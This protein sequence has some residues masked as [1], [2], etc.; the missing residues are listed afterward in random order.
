VRLVRIGPEP[1]CETGTRLGALPERETRQQSLLGPRQVDP[2]TVNDQVEAAD[3]L[4]AAAARWPRR[5]LER[6]WE[7]IRQPDGHPFR[8]CAIREINARSIH[9]VLV[10]CDGEGVGCDGASRCSR[11]ER[12]M[13]DGRAMEVAVTSHTAALDAVVQ[14]TAVEPARSQR[15]SSAERGDTGSDRGES[16]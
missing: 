12:S 1:A 4:Q 11:I 6:R 2:L 14:G 5:V 8:P 3:E 9:R 7:A 16:V 13:P 15:L 10:V